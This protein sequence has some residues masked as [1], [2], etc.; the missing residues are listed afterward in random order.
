MSCA[1]SFVRGLNSC[2]LHPQR[3]TAFGCDPDLAL[4][5]V[6]EPVELAGIVGGRLCRTPDRLW[7]ARIARAPRDHMDVQLRH[8][9][10]ERRHVELVAGG[11]LLEGTRYARNLGHQLRALDLLEVDDLAGA[12]APRNEQ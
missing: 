2:G 6:D 7:P 3:S 10:A 4:D 12:R 9:I 1:G 8:R 11:H 5:R